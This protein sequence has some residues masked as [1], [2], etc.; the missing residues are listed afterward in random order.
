MNKWRSYWQRWRDAT[1]LRVMPTLRGRRRDIRMATLHQAAAVASLQLIPLPRTSQVVQWVKNPPAM[2]EAQ[3]RDPWIRKT[4][5]RRAWQPT[6]IFLPR[7]SP[8]TEEPG[9]LQSTGSQRVKYDWSNTAD[10]YNPYL[11]SLHSLYILPVILFFSLSK[12]CFLGWP[13]RIRDFQNA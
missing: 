8:W 11:W 12:F 10:T 13:T 9:E 4:P 3:V 5:W 2:Q 6:P 7:E 1:L